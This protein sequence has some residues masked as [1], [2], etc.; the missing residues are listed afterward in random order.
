MQKQSSTFDTLLCKLKPYL[1]DI[2]K[3]KL[4]LARHISIHILHNKQQTA[5]YIGQPFRI[6]G[7]VH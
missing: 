5:N 7:I 1:L 3:I 4:Y 2:T 6:T